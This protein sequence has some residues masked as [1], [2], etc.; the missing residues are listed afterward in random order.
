MHERRV[1]GGF[2]I[3]PEQRVLE[4]KTDD[5]DNALTVFG[6]DEEARIDFFGDAIV[7]EFALNPHRRA[8]VL[9][10]PAVGFRQKRGNGSNVVTCRVTDPQVHGV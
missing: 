5:A 1:S 3:R 7:G 6:D 2:Q 8:V 9:V 10:H 4:L